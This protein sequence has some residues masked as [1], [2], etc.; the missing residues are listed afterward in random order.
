[1]AIDG[2]IVATVGLSLDIIGVCVLFIF[3]LPF[4]MAK[5]FI[6]NSPF[7]TTEPTAEQLAGS[8]RIRA[9]ERRERRINRIGQWSGIG[10]LVS[11]FGLQIVALWV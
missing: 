10:L 1:M 7:L 2:D 3:G 4:R 8:E 6:S 9:Q 5:D 11:G